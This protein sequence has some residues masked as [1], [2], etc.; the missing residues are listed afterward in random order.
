MSAPVHLGIGIPTYN[1]APLLSRLLGSLK[2]EAHLLEQI[3]VSDNASTD[4]TSAVL[5]EFNDLPIQWV[6][7]S[8]NN[9][10]DANIAFCYDNTP[11]RYIWVLGDDDEVCPGSISKVLEMLSKY[12]PKALYLNHGTM[13]LDGSAVSK[14]PRLPE[15][16]DALVFSDMEILG[17]L[18][19]AWAILTGLVVHAAT[20]RSFLVKHSGAYLD[21]TGMQFLPALANMIEQHGAIYSS[22]RHYNYACG[23]TWSG[24]TIEKVCVDATIKLLRQERWLYRKH[25]RA[26]R[27][28]TDEVASV[29]IANL[30]RSLSKSDRSALIRVVWKTLRFFPASYEAQGK[31]PAR[32]FFHL[33]QAQRRAEKRSN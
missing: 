9:G 18:K 11:G 27:E 7:Q 8:Q 4:D 22:F 32:A 33:C 6:A 21:G 1:R 3:L 5:K 31:T 13:G 2:D 20:F 30:I 10:M 29:H 24:L 25:P 26:T 19:S 14:A 17:L 16:P 28:W 15:S 12:Q 23:N